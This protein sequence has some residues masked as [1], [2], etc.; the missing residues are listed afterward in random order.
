MFILKVNH[1]ITHLLS[2]S[3]KT[4]PY[5]QV[6]LPG[7]HISLGVFHKIFKMLEDECSVLDIKITEKLREKKEGAGN[8]NFQSFIESV[9]KMSCVETSVAKLNDEIQFLNDAIH[10]QVLNDPENEMLL[11]NLYTNHLEELHKELQDKV[12][13]FKQFCFSNNQISGLKSVILN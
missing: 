5:F 6:A 3:H 8:E 9:E 12:F 1:M 11:I 10:V 2:K 7:L 13:L 4:L